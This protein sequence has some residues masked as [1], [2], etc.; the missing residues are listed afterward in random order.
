LRRPN[1]VLLKALRVAGIRPAK[2]VTA[3]PSAPPPNGSPVSPTPTT[4]AGSKLSLIRFGRI[5]LLV[6]D[7]VGYIPFEA[8]AASLFFQLVSSRS[9]RASVIA[10]SN[11]PFG[12]LGRVLR[13]RHRRAP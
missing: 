10:T 1:G 3:S 9:E 11:K 6:I 2:R 7:E 12:S 4:P 13:R 8:D 5:P